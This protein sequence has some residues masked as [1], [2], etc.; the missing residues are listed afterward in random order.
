MPN[1]QNGKIYKIYCL[2]GNI[3]DVY[4]GSTIQALSKRIGEHRSKYK[5]KKTA[6]GIN[7]S[8]I[9]FGKY[10]IENCIIE[11]VENYPCN[12][13][14]ELLS[15]EGYYQ[16]N[17][18]CVNK[19]ISGRTNKEYYENTKDDRHKTSNEYYQKNKE[20]LTE[21]HICECGGRYTTKNKKTHIKTKNHILAILDS[22]KNLNDI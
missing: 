16:K 22:G 18:H 13:I 17:N 20:I 14:E 7:T 2:N 8:G 19:K 1:Y 10:G 21:K 6:S 5:I 4:Y 12:T 9:L 15:R 3:D 11:L